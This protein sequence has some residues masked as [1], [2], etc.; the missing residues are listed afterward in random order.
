MNKDIVK[1]HWKEIKGKLKQQWGKLTDDE[2][3]TMQGT[4]EELEGKLQRHYGYQ[5]EQAEREI[6]K[7]L[8]RNHLTEKT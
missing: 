6:E 3:D 5:K 7:F 8:E 2:I 4:F 1:G